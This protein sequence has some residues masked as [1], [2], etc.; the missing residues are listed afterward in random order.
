MVREGAVAME[1]AGE[2]G[3]G[4]GAGSQDVGVGSSA[5]RG[6]G[7]WRGTLCRGRGLCEA[8]SSEACLP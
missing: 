2:Q 1:K 3:P 7:S 4:A 6:L 5:H 8:H